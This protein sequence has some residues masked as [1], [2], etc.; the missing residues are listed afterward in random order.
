MYGFRQIRI[1]RMPGECMDFECPCNASITDAPGLCRL[2]MPEERTCWGC[3]E[4]ACMDC[5]YP[6]VTEI[7]DARGIYALRMPVE[8]VN[9]GCSGVFR[10]RMRGDI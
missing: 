3:S 10:L 2:G 9:C 6:G 5:R 8:H 7:T 1:L 4:N